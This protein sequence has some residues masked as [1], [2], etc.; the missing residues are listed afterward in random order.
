[1]EVTKH[2]KTLLLAALLLG[3]CASTPGP[4]GLSGA[5]IEPVQ[6]VALAPEPAMPSPTLIR[7]LAEVQVAIADYPQPG[8]ERERWRW[9]AQAVETLLQQGLNDEAAMRLSR[10]RAEVEAASAAY[11]REHAGRYLEQAQRFAR[12]SA[13]QHDQLR[14]MD[15]AWHTGDYPVA[16]RLGQQ[17]VRQL[18]TAQD[19]VTVRAGDTLAAISARPDV[20]DNPLLWPLLQQANPGLI[21]HP[22]RLTTGWRL[23]YVVHPQLEEI[24]AA[25][26]YAKGYQP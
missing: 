18:W 3:G 4:D 22:A 25:V 16:Y 7:G 13:V 6:V 2:S 15:F 21:R 11:Y 8:F 17:L 1:M 9:R 14:A 20:Y 12:L 24:F 5:P 10:L 19:W 26:E 23:R